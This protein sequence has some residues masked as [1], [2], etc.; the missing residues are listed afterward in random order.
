MADPDDILLS[1]SYVSKCPDELNVDGRTDE[2]KLS[3]T[4]VYA[5]RT[6]GKMILAVP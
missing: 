1:V 3:Q 4:S 6:L 2:T 5:T